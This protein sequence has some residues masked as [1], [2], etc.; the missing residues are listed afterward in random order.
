MFTTVSSRLGLPECVTDLSS[1]HI[2]LPEII[3]YQGFCEEIDVFVALSEEKQQLVELF[4]QVQRRQGVVL[5][6]NCPLNQRNR[7]V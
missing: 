3:K 1:L 4:V 6:A 2:Y 5:D 7:S